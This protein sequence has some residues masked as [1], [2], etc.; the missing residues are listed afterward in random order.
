MRKELF[1]KLSNK[2]RLVYLKRREHFTRLYFYLGLASFIG[3][4]IFSI[5]LDKNRFLG[6]IIGFTLIGLC[7]LI[8]LIYVIE[9]IYFNS[10]EEDLEEKYKWI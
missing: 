5:L 4:F 1:N 10:K 8:L 7:I 2:E 9:L 3:L 6:L